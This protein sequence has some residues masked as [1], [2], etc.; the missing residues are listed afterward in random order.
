[1]DDSPVSEGARVVIRDYDPKIDAPFVYASWR[2]AL[3]FAEIRDEKLSDAFYSN[4]SKDIRTLLN[5]KGVTTR[6]A[7]VVNEPD[8]FVG[9][10]VM[11][12]THLHWVYVKES[13]RRQGVA[14][15]LSKGFRT[16]SPPL[17]KVSKVIAAS[18]NLEEFHGEDKTPA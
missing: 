5:Q 7:S 14:K 10:S 1:M 11:S 18:H 12:G 9:Y 8:F 13:Y 2:N 15:L 3:W 17:T 4:A 16:I 6:I